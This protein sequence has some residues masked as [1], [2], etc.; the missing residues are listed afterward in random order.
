MA[1]SSAGGGG[2]NGGGNG[3]GNGGGIKADPA[4]L[5]EKGFDQMTPLI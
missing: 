1:S 3:N 2:G 4:V 5:E